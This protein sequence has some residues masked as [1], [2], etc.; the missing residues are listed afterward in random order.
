[1]PAHGVV[2]APQ[3]AAVVQ[4]GFFGGVNVE[5]VLVHR[6]V[7][8][9]VGG[10]DVRADAGERFVHARALPVGR[11]LFGAD[12]G[13][14]PAVPRKEGVKALDFADTHRVGGKRLATVLVVLAVDGDE[15]FDVFG[16]DE[17][18][19][20]RG[21][22]GERAAGGNCR[23]DAAR[24]QGADGGGDAFRQVVAA[25]A[26]EGFVNVEEDDFG[27]FHAL[28][29]VGPGMMPRWTRAL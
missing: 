19:D 7:Q 27:G 20:F 1:M 8:V 29:H 24:F 23:D 2:V 12:V 5:Q 25:F 28:F 26:V 15:Q 16:G 11:H 21:Q 10:D 9:V 18:A 6:L 13:V 22:G 4:R 14:V 17:F 3:F